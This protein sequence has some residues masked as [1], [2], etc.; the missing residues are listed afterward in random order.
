MVVLASMFPPI[1]ERRWKPFGEVLMTLPRRIHSSVRKVDQVPI[2]SLQL[3]VGSR[4]DA[5]GESIMSVPAHSRRLSRPNRRHFLDITQHPAPPLPQHPA[6]N[7]CRP[8]PAYAGNVSSVFTE[9]PFQVFPHPP[10]VAYCNG[11]V[12]TVFSALPPP[13]PVS[14]CGSSSC[15]AIRD[16]PVQMRDATCQTD[17]S[18]CWCMDTTHVLTGFH[19]T[20]YVT[21]DKLTRDP[22]TS[23]NVELS[24]S[25]PI[26]QGIL[27][28]IA[29]PMAPSYDS[30]VVDCEFEREVDGDVGGS[31]LLSMWSDNRISALS[32]VGSPILSPGGSPWQSPPPSLRTDEGKVEEVKSAE[33]GTCLQ[34]E[35]PNSHGGSPWQFPPPSLRTGGGKVQEVNHVENGTQPQAE[36]TNGLLPLDWP[37]MQS[38]HIRCV[39]KPKEVVNRSQL[40]SWLSLARMQAKHPSDQHSALATVVE[41]LL[42][43]AKPPCDGHRHQLVHTIVTTLL[44][45]LKEEW[46]RLDS[47]SVA[48]LR[49]FV[50]KQADKAL[51][52]S[53]AIQKQ[54]EVYEPKAK[55]A[56]VI[57]RARSRLAYA[58]GLLISRL[59]WLKN[60]EGSPAWRKRIKAA[61]SVCREFVSVF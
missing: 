12:S 42:K 54:I 57:L 49:G 14:G 46:A 50:Q 28:I 30:G 7:P 16:R 32:P 60:R 55:V 44:Q 27:S 15:Q 34:T 8:P 31:R 40:K 3:N 29:D 1:E 18:C 37:R 36:K 38:A 51:L 53:S 59:S 20:D 26:V 10:P 19:F 21:C 6:V 43:V 58:I 52:Y 4:H 48:D 9:S 45:P 17:P 11:Y 23:P 2:K 22:V 5:D 61:I 39:S 35:K 25:D 41:A 24:C 13:P 33:N 47:Y 56:E